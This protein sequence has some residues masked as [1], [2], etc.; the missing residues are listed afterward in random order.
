MSRIIFYG[1][2]FAVTWGCNCSLPSSHWNP[3][4]IQPSWSAQLRH[5]IC[6]NIH[7][8]H[9]MISQQVWTNRLMFHESST[10]FSTSVHHRSSSYIDQELSEPLTERRPHSGLTRL[11]L[12]WSQRIL[13][14][15]CRH[16]QQA[17]SKNQ[18][19]SN[20]HILYWCCVSKA[21]KIFFFPIPSGAWESKV[22]C[23]HHNESWICLELK[24]LKPIEMPFPDSSIQGWQIGVA[25]QLG[26]AVST[27]GISE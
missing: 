9:N 2:L 17:E 21:R 7:W 3:T 27:H 1:F 6:C 11:W 25:R 15:F 4:T 18:A 16:I 5:I 10:F 26:R 20:R 22:Q 13:S 24:N 19:E 8:T 23:V 14:D 12:S